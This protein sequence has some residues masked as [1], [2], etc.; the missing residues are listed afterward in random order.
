MTISTYASS[1]NGK[2]DARII[3]KVG[4]SMTNVDYLVFAEILSSTESVKMSLKATTTF[5]RRSPNICR[6]FSIL[7]TVNKFRIICILQF[8]ILEM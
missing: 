5:H 2:F 4:E 8:F 7:C 6:R 1:Y 3:A